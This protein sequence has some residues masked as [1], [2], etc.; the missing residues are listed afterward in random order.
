MPRVESAIY[1]IIIIIVNK[2]R[3]YSAH[4]DDTNKMDVERS[5][6]SLYYYYLCCHLS[7]NIATNEWTIDTI[8]SINQQLTTFRFRTSTKPRELSFFCFHS[9]SELSLFARIK[10]SYLIRLKKKIFFSLDI[11]NGV[12]NI[13]IHSIILDTYR[14]IYIILDGSFCTI[15]KYFFFTESWRTQLHDNDN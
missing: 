6:W 12:N 4:W 5:I 1:F 14:Y 9:K 13:S 3:W 2:M 7:F 15:Q 10:C 11:I 8:E